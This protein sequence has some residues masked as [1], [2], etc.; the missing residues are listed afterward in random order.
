MAADVRKL[1]EVRLAL[2]RGD[3]KAIGLFALIGLPY[4][5]KFLWSPLLDRSRCRWAGVAA[6]W[7][8]SISRCCCRF[9]R[10]DS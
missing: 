4:T 6:G 5:W 10:W 2:R 9:L 3:L 1:D 8:C 7:R